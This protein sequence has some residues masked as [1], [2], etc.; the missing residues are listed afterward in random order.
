MVK[1]SNFIGSQKSSTATT[2]PVTTGPSYENEAPSQFDNVPAN[3]LTPTDNPSAW[4]ITDPN[5]TIYTGDGAATSTSKPLASNQVIGAIADKLGIKPSRKEPLVTQVENALSK[6]FGVVKTKTPPPLSTVKEKNPL[7][8]AGDLGFSALPDTN[9]SKTTTL[10][11][12]VN[13]MGLSTNGAEG[14]Q[15]NAIAK[16]LGVPLTTTSS[17][18]GAPQTQS[19]TK[20]AMGI[21]NLNAQ[22]LTELQ[23]QLYQAGYYSSDIQP[24]TSTTYTPGHFD[25]PTMQAWGNLLTD[26]A[27]VN[28]SGKQV[29]WVQ[30]L[31]NETAA[32]NA[33]GGISSILGKTASPVTVAT[34]SELSTALQ[35]AFEEEVGHAPTPAELQQFTA[36]YDQQQL[37][38]ASD[39]TPTTE[40][41]L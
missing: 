33:Q 3:K 1:T 23:N 6:Q 14:D 36:D 34:D 16:Q 37:S 38:H 41:T 35:S 31:Q 11:N 2:V 19:I 26:T 8:A 40:T 21:Y 15:W 22:Q 10:D 24:G 9:G 32:E 29:T 17:T 4:G 27:T 20:A 5:L 13:K 30:Q 39:I 12:I 18:P 28:A 7:T 25:T